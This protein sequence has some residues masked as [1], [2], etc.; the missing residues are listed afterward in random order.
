MQQARREN[1]GT[2]RRPN[3]MLIVMDDMG[4][5]IDLLPTI[6]DLAGLARDRCETV[7]LGRERPEK[8]AEMQAAWEACEDG[9]RT[10]AT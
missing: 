2:G 4:H 5:C 10:V 9:Y 6:V 8:L 7:D 1:T 3:V